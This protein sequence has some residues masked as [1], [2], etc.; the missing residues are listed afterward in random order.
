MTKFNQGMKSSNRTDCG[1]PPDFYEFLDKH[2]HF[3]FDP[4]PLNPDFDGLAIEWGHCN[5]VNPP[6]GREIVKWCQKAY[7]ECKQGK[8][9]IMLV[10]AR[11]D[12][13]WWHEYAMKANFICFLKGRLRF[14]DYKDGAPYP[15]A[16]LIFFPQKRPYSFPEIRTIS[17]TKDGYKFDE[18][19]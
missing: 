14:S 16:V 2:F 13:K 4:C 9:V 12:T 6:Y 15:S 11:T 3:T 18:R 8:I 17:K 5:F 10:A 19:S 1:T 7:E